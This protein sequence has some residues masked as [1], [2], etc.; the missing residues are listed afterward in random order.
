MVELMPTWG[1][2]SLHLS[3]HHLHLSLHHLFIGLKC[4]MGMSE[5]VVSEQEQ[6]GA[7]AGFRSGLED[8]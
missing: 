1:G 4:M 2:G 7:K 5:R 3:L 6:S 8:R